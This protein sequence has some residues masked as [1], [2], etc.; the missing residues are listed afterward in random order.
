MIA[1]T[2]ETFISSKNDPKEAYEEFLHQKSIDKLAELRYD[3]V[4]HML[5][6]YALNKLLKLICICKKWFNE[7]S[8]HLYRVVEM[9]LFILACGS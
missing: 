6:K 4:K 1:D 8:L 2:D 3:K 5:N 9:L 7:Y